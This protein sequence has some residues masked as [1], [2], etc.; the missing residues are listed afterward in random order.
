METL[1]TAVI[2]IAASIATKTIEITSENVGEKVVKFL[3]SLRKKSP[4][5][6]NA[7]EQAPEQTLDYGKA[8]VEVKSVAASNP[9]FKEAMEELVIAA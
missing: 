9:E 6:V 5:T 2:A 4:Q 1:S 3:D 7:I 8:V